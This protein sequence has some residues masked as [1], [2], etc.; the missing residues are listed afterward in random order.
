MREVESC[1]AA[2]LNAS[3]ITGFGVKKQMMGKRVSYLLFFRKRLTSISFYLADY[4]TVAGNN[5]KI[6]TRLRQ[7]RL[8]DEF[9]VRFSVHK[10]IM[11]A[12]LAAIR[13]WQILALQ[14]LS[15]DRLRNA[16]RLLKRLIRGS[17][18][19]GHVPRT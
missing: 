8:L 19:L 1:R 11:S 2:T 12:R 5:N 9:D 13:T 15:P 14:V 6:N 10:Q 16:R 7:R 17:G 4:S 3:L 18:F